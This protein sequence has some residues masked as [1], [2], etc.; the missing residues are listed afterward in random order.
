MIED[1]LAGLIVAIGVVMIIGPL[2]ALIVSKLWT[3]DLSG[4]AYGGSGIFISLI[5]AAIGLFIMA[6]LPIGLVMYATLSGYIDYRALSGIIKLVAPLEVYKG[7]SPTTQRAQN[8][9]HQ[10]TQ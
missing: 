5:K 6:G 10:Q 2:L 3:C 9:Q 8:I 7:T 4:G 1:F